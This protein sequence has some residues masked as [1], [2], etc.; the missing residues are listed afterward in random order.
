MRIKNRAGIAKAFTHQIWRLQIFVKQTLKFILR[1]LPGQKLY[2]SQ[3]WDCFNTQT[4][5][6]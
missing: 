2:M 6:L 3:M 5:D 4:W 1:C